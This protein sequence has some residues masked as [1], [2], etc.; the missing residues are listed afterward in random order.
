VIHVPLE[1]KLIDRRT[2]QL[3]LVAAYQV[4]DAIRRGK[5]VLVTCNAGRNRSGLIVALALHLLSGQPAA[6]IIGYVKKA[7]PGALS[8]P[9]FVRA[10]MEFAG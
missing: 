10:I 3:A 5:K 6:P 2:W 7:R 8:N 9:S 1:D 4:T